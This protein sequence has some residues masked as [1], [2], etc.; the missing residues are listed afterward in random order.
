MPS[1]KVITIDCAGKCSYKE[2]GEGIFKECCDRCAKM[3]GEE[4]KDGDNHTVIHFT[5]CLGCEHDD[6]KKNN[7]V[8]T[9]YESMAQATTCYHWQPYKSIGSWPE[10]TTDK[11]WYAYGFDQTSE[12]VQYV[13]VSHKFGCVADRVD[14][15]LTV[16]VDQEENSDLKQERKGKNTNISVINKKNNDGGQPDSPVSESR[17]SVQ[18]KTTDENTTE[19]RLGKVKSHDGI[20]EVSC[21]AAD[22]NNRKQ[23]K[24][25]NLKEVDCKPCDDVPKLIHACCMDCAE[26]AAKADRAYSSDTRDFIQCSGCDQFPP[27]SKYR[28][29][30]ETNHSVK[31]PSIAGVREYLLAQLQQ[32]GQ[33]RGHEQCRDAGAN[34]TGF[35]FFLGN[36]LFLLCCG[37]FFKYLGCCGCFHFMGCC[38]FVPPKTERNAAVRNDE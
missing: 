5:D 35:R 1:P 32:T 29:R 30:R 25:F 3:D 37:C 15:W 36:I 20:F 6:M 11:S 21:A 10:K 26:M 13:N 12:T 34:C 16:Q 14:K 22:R 4:S 19:R 23:T 38:F 33:H 31:G 17:R 8:P 24:A 28:N 18:N 2:Y 9:W 27:A 7:P